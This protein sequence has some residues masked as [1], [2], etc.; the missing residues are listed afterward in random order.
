MRRYGVTIANGDASFR[1]VLIDRQS[2]CTLHRPA[3]ALAGSNWTVIRGNAAKLPGQW[4]NSAANSHSLG[5]VGGEVQS[6]CAG[7]VGTLLDQHFIFNIISSLS[8]S[9]EFLLVYC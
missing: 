2:P 1:A 8:L 7:V 3:I 4:A 6:S 5:F 9:I